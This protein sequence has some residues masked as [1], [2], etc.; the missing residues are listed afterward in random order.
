[1]SFVSCCHHER[2]LLTKYDAKGSPADDHFGLIDQHRRI[3]QVKGVAYSLDALLEIANP[4]ST[5]SE[6]AVFSTRPD[7]N[8]DDREFVNVNG[9]E[10]SLG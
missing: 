7:A 1:M 8:M 2:Q 6:Q 10:Y 3:E 4:D 9:I 5:E